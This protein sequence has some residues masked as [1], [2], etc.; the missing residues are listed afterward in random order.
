MRVGVQLSEIDDFRRSRRRRAGAAGQHVAEGTHDSAF[1][2]I[3]TG[4]RVALLP[5][6]VPLAALT[7][8]REM[9]IELQRS[10]RDR[11]YFA[12][13]SEF[14]KTESWYKD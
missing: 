13:Q 14:T 1:E 11:D 6:S 12:R 2:F 10:G 9:L 3:Q 4:F 5:S 7:A 8:A